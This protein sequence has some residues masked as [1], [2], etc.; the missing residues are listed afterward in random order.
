VLDQAIQQDPEM[1]IV[2]VGNAVKA[3]VLNG[4]GFVNQQLYLIP[5]FFSQQADAPVARSGDRRQPPQ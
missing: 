5:M 2:T 1:R 3:L 4:L